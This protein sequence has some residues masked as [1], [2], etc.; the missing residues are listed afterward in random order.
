MFD[1]SIQPSIYTSHSLVCQ[2]PSDPDRV[3]SLT[4]SGSASVS[5]APAPAQSNCQ[6]Q[7]SKA[8]SDLFEVVPIVGRG[9]IRRFMQRPPIDDVIDTTAHHHRRNSAVRERPST[10]LPETPSF[11]LGPVENGRTA[12]GR[13]KPRPV[14]E[15][16][17]VS[18]KLC[19]AESAITAEM[20]RDCTARLKRL[21]LAC[22]ETIGNR[23]HAAFQV[24]D[25]I[26]R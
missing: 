11:S 5:P 8:K 10:T 20:E 25:R 15:C 14:T 3:Q 18:L 16:Q 9:P 19:E 26:H 4:T 21:K 2:C 13:V 17:A 6:L 1:D 7:Q 12:L 24:H 22:S 23:Q